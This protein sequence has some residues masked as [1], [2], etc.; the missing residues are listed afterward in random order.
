MAW[1]RSERNGTVDSRL[2][3]Y[4][5]RRL[6]WHLTSFSSSDTKWPGHARALKILQIV[7]QSLRSITG[8]RMSDVDQRELNNLWW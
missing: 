7:T 1:Q 5:S 6:Q 3:A 2:N 8:S 4:G